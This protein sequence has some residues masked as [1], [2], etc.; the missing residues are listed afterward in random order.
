MSS[1]DILN[2]VLIIFLLTAA[3]AIIAV[4]LFLVK[5]LKSITILAAS[6]DDTAQSVKEKLQMKALAALPP[7]LIG[8]VSR[9]FKRGR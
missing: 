3:G 7:L 4:T 2:I 6:L 1:Q 5:A 9:I 8:I